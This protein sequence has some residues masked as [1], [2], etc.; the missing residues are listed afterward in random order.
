MI[1]TAYDAIHQAQRKLDDED[2]TIWSHAEL[3][4]YAKDGYNQ[5]CR[6]TKCL[7]DMFVI[8]NV[9]PTGNWGSD[10][11]RHL[12]EQTPGMK[13][14]RS[15]RFSISTSRSRCACLPPRRSRAIPAAGRGVAGGPEFGAS[16]GPRFLASLTRPP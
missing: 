7:F 11:Q 14:A 1:T 4:L 8:E 12:A 6:Q 16:P 5:L 9:P 3:L 13:L 10:L 2:D 15:V